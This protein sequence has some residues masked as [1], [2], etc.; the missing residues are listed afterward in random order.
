MRPFAKHSDRWVGLILLIIVG[1]LFADTFT[2]QTRPFVPLNT[3]FWPRVILAG[4]AICAVILLLKGRVGSEEHEPFRKAA[5][6]VFL[7]ASSFVL[8]LQLGGFLLA[9]A[10]LGTLG[11]YWLSET[12]TLRTLLIAALYGLVVSG[13]VFALF[14]IVLEVQLPKGSLF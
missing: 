1:I 8:A 4:L 7:G 12:R 9:S 5:F 2:F 3:A 13:A 6:L 10:A 11:F 14:K